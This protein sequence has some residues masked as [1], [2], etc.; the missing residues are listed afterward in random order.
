MTNGVVAWCLDSA[1]PL[2]LQ[3]GRGTSQGRRIQPRP[4]QQ[5]TR[6]RGH[7]HNPHGSRSRPCRAGSL[8]GRNL[9]RFDL[10]VPMARAVADS[11]TIDRRFWQE[12]S[13]HQAR[14]SRLAD[15]ARVIPP[16]RIWAGGIGSLRVGPREYA[17]FG[18]STRGFSCAGSGGTRRCAHAAPDVPT[19]F[20]RRSR[21]RP[22]C[23]S[24]WR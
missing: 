2:A 6:E 4:R 20:C 14:E 12:A 5:Q 9:D 21:Y 16:S 15:S 19:G 3:S 8:R 10:P 18:R 13:R 7:P 11:A 23:S 22:S 1:R 24:K 17:W